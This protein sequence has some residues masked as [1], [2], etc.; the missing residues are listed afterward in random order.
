MS[1]HME[2]CGLKDGRNG[3]CFPSGLCDLCRVKVH[4]SGLCDL[5]AG[6]KCIF[7]DCVTCVQGQSATVTLCILCIN[8]HLFQ[9]IKTALIRVAL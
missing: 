7:L 1:V 5:C 6:S 2:L 3:M 8:Q 4:L 9:I